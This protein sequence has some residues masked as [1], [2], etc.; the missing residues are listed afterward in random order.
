MQAAEHS[1]TIA[2]EVIQTQKGAPNDILS[3]HG[4]STPWVLLSPV[5][6]ALIMVSQPYLTLEKEVKKMGETHKG[7]TK[8][9]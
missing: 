9:T 4:A 7:I 5:V 8:A 2:E 6:S 1:N 3:V